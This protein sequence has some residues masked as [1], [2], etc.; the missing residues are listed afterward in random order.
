[1]VHEYAIRGCSRQND[2]SKNQRSHGR[3]VAVTPANSSMRHLSYGR[4]IL[5]SSKPQVSF[6]NGEQEIWSNL[7]FRKWRGEDGGK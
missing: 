5:N 3:H 7:P 4:I 2:L 6:S 1:V